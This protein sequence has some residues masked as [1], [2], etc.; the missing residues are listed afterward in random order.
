MYP[1]TIIKTRYQGT[2]ESGRWA[3]FPVEFNDVPMDVVGDDIET[4]NWWSSNVDMVGVGQTPEAALENLEDKMEWP[5]YATFA[6]GI[7]R[8]KWGAWVTK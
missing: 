6:P 4:M 3:A 1:V 2:Y 7:F 5:E 8:T